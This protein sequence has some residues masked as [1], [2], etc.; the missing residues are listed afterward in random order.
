QRKPAP[1]DR[2]R[3]DGPPAAGGKQ[4]ELRSEVEEFLDRMKRGN[5]GEP[6]RKPR[7]P[8][9]AAGER[10]DARRD[11]P[12]PRR[13][14]I[15][16]L[17]DD[18]L[19]AEQQA[20]VAAEP[21]PRRVAMPPLE[22]EQRPTPTKK[23]PPAERRFAKKVGE[24]ASGLSQRIAHADDMAEARI[25]QKF[26]HKLG[27]LDSSSD[28]AAADAMADTSTSTTSDGDEQSDSESPTAAESIAAMLREPDN[29]R[30]A[31]ILNEILRRPT[32]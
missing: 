9:P 2:P 6:D 17:V 19:V 13:P 5:D 30:N 4:A 18:D 27:R 7:E 21:P 29:I 14:R 10:P 3:G 22:D 26:D 32:I 31:V 25:H 12:P 20:R 1:A 23:S 16:V 11:Q 8:R 24:Q 28:S 15:E